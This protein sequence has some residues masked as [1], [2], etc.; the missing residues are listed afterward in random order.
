MSGRGS[1]VWDTLADAGALV[2]FRIPPGLYHAVR[3]YVTGQ[4]WPPSFTALASSTFQ[5]CSRTSVSRC[6][7]TGSPP[8][9]IPILLGAK[10]S[11]KRAARSSCWSGLPTPRHRVSALRT[12][13]IG[14]SRRRRR[15]RFRFVAR[16][17]RDRRV[18]RAS[19]D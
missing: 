5:T 15:R 11:R 4:P 3:N 2:R 1:V 19:L 17:G 14:F 13:M 16:V 12:P 6:G 18:P 10:R 8:R 9:S 7:A